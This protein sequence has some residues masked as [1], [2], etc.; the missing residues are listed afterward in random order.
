MPVYKYGANRFLTAFHDLFTRA[1]LFEYHTGFRASNKRMLM[2]MPMLENSH[3]FDFD[4]GPQRTSLAIELEKSCVRRST[5]GKD[6]P[7]I[8]L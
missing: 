3:D 6:R 5:L 7:S 8:C 2:E 1:K 4:I